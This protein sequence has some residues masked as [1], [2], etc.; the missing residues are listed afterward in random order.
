MSSN[1]DG[2]KYCE[3]V[4]EQ[5]A[6]VGIDSKVTLNYSNRWANADKHSIG[7][8]KYMLTIDNYD[9]SHE[10][11]NVYRRTLKGHFIVGRHK[12]H[13]FVLEIFGLS[14]AV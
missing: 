9:A 4:R 7:D 13:E 3:K 6:S 1:M 14:Y 10:T 5:L 12:L 11:V 2:S 8:H